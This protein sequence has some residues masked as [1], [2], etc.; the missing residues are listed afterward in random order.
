MK[1][2]LKQS[3]EKFED[4]ALKI[5]VMWPQDKE[6]QQLPGAGRGKM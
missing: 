4:A 3:R 1:V 6:W 2:M 5:I